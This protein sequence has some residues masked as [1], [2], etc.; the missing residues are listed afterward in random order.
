[1][2]ALA[3]PTLGT[4]DRALELVKLLLDITPPQYTTVKLLSGGSEVTE[5]AIKMARQYHKQTGHGT[6]DKILSHYPADHGGAGPA[7]AARGGAPLRR[8]PGAPPG[9]RS[10]LPTP[11]RARLP[12]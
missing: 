1:R 11:R 8:P 10:P 9:R 12:L 7:L 4:S 6:K 2:L 5:A 3:A